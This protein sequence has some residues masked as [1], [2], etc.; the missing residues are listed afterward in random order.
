MNEVVF[1]TVGFVATLTIV[2]IVEVVCNG[3]LTLK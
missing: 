2:C 3:R 1:F